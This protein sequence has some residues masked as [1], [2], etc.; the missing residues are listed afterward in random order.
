MHSRGSDN[1]ALGKRGT[2]WTGCA[3]ISPSLRQGYKNFKEVKCLWTERKPDER[4]RR[5]PMQKLNMVD[6][7]ALL[8]QPLDKPRFVVDG[9]LPTAHRKSAKAGLC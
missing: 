2:V 7:D 1:A 6:A 4:E 8:Y 9:L 5:T 3:Y